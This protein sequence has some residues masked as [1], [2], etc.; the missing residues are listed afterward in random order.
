[1]RA[2]QQI[3]QLIDALKLTGGVEADRFAANA[4]L[5]GAGHHVKSGQDCGELVEGDPA[6]RH[7]RQRDI[8]IDLLRND[9]AD[10]D[11]TDPRHQHQ[12]PAQLF[13]IAHQLRVGK[14]VARDSEEKAKHI[15]KVIVDERGDYA[16]G[17]KAAGVTDPAT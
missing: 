6:R 7:L 2:D 10:S 14:T 1:M 12:L 4:D 11:F 13:G 3:S 9:A 8:H 16:R 17:E 15:A 5:P